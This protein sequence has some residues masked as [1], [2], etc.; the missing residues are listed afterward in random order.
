MRRLHRD[1]PHHVRPGVSATKVLNEL[2]K[3]IIMNT[4]SFEYI[5]LSDIFFGSVRYKLIKLN[6]RQL[7]GPRKYSLSYLV[8]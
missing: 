2:V 3:W 8:S 4:V 5:G 6:T 7:L 1:M